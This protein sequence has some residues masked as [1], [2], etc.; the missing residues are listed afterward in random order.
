MKKRCF[1]VILVLLWAPLVRA[2]STPYQVKSILE[3]EAQ[4]PQ[5]VE[6]QL[7]EYLM[8][9]VPQLPPIATTTPE[10]WTAE[11]GQIRQRVLASVVFHG[12]PKEWVSSP[13]HFEDMGAIASG[14]GYRRRKLRYEIIPGFYSAAILY[15]PEN[16]QGKVPAVLNV[17]GHHGATGKS[18]PFQQ[19]MC[20]N[21]ALR[22]MVALNLEFLGMGELFDK[23]NAHGYGGHLDLV[24]AN[25]VG[26]FYLAMRRGLD[27][28]WVH[29]NVDQ[30]RI[31][32]TGLSGGGWQ[33]I[34][35]SSLDE[36]VNISIPVAGYTALEGRLAL[37]P[38]TEAGDIEQNATDLL[39]GQDYST[40]TAIRA[41]RPTLLINNAEDRCCFRAAMVKPYI[42]EAVRPFFGL[43]GKEAA[44]Q[45][46]ENTSISDHNYELDNREQAYRFL[47]Q[48]FGLDVAPGFSPAPAALKG[49][50]LDVAPGF[51]PAP[52]ALKGGAT[53]S[54]S[55]REIA[56]GDDI[57]SYSELA[58]GLPKDNLTILALARKLA[59]GITRPAIP[60]DAAAKAAWA[61]AERAKLNA[62]VRYSPVMVQQAWMVANAKHNGIESNSFRFLLSNGLGATGVWLKDIPT[63]EGMPLTIV[64]NDK[65]KKGAAAEVWDRL[66][67]VAN[68]MD[69]NEQVLVLDLLFTGDA[70]PEGPLFLFPEM[71]AATGNR[72]LGLE[73][74]QL[75]GIAI[76]ARARF[77]APSV[78]IESTG[79]RS[80]VEAL[81]AAALS[82]Q[83]FS[84]VAVQGG[85][86]SLKYLL[87]KPVSYQDFAD[88][89]CLD[90][91][92]D[93]DLDRL[94]LIA[95]PT[96][97][98]EHDFVEEAG[99]AE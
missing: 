45:F 87:D 25:E 70:A 21:E 42:F 69:R 10:T 48:Y 35:L 33:T 75:I 78:R 82:R 68:R 24:G 44:L 63:P 9:Q 47:A 76:W 73:A 40:L 4:S 92:K 15:T 59:G 41:P 18:E 89:F 28:L 71:L 62:L 98:H 43:Y 52:A 94:I 37:A 61:D 91:Y 6:S 56:V 7:Q 96:Q 14:K 88:L 11:G 97:V 80:Q 49:G 54:A 22:G 20:I 50:A 2:Q 3:T 93:F 38:R 95:G 60:S 39:V 8:K 23:E 26:L 46:Y 99:K 12:W 31:A 27:Y 86:H 64:L 55:D 90:F 32:V 58:A 34:M 19:K 74:A 84:E 36:R 65:G 67:E 51:S 5:V 29:P 85:M 66:P 13:P 53:V 1:L 30:K 77:N 72:P 83:L 17:M 57:K 81:V 16:L 79:I